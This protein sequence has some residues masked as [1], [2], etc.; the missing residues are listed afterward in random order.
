MVIPF[1]SSSVGVLT[2]G[3]LVLVP[4]SCL[5]AATSVHDG[6]ALS[7]SESELTASSFVIQSVL[8]CIFIG[9]AAF[10]RLTHSAP[11]IGVIVKWWSGFILMKKKKN[12]FYIIEFIL[13]YLILNLHLKNLVVSIHLNFLMKI[14]FHMVDVVVIDL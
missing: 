9:S 4:G 11:A 12:N 14:V 3:T 6:A 7:N 2:D 13:E 10:K 1:V 8:L 5:K